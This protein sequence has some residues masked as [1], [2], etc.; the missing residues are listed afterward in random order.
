M[1]VLYVTTNSFLRSTTSSLDAVLRQLRPKGLVPVMVFKE[2]GPWQEELAATGV[3]CY[4]HPLTIPDKLR[5]IRSLRA[6]WPLIRI[7]KHERIELIH[8]NEHDHYPLLRLVAR[9]TKRPIVV[10]LHWNIDAGFGQ[11]AFAPPYGPSAMQFT[12]RAQ[13]EASR[14]GV[15]NSLAADRVKLLMCGLDCDAYVRRGDDGQGLRKQWG[16]EQ[17]AVVLGTASAIK[18]RKRLEYF[19]RLIAK[20]RRNGTA[21]LGVIAGGGRFADHSYEA[22]LRGLIAE[23]QIEHD[24]KMIGNLD[25]ITPFMKAIDIFVSTSQ[26][27][28]FG[29]SV[30]EAMAC[31]KPA[32]GFDAG[33]VPEVI[34]D[35]WSLVPFGDVDR[36][37]ER[38]ATLVTDPALR[39]QKGA[40]AEQ[41]VR[42]HFDAPVLA[43]RQAE[44]YREILGRSL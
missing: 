28:T 22:H 37:A 18:P 23:E 15:P 34:G 7:V 27:E 6:V 39:H 4:V 2:P 25:P 32:I 40:R 43:A 24:C 11:W 17:D 12:S 29:M 35:P 31:G 26:W 20:L 10:T 36:L 21:V 5:P 14:A 38:A 44:I 16:V 8:C 30:C 3:P 9:W 42:E 1:R 33:S 41:R 13:L 19:V